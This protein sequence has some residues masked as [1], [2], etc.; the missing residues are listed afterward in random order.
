MSR[1]VQKHANFF[2]HPV[3][4]ELRKNKL[5]LLRQLAHTK[6]DRSDRKKIVVEL[7]EFNLVF[8]DK[9]KELRNEGKDEDLRQIVAEMKAN[10]RKAWAI[11]RRFLGKESDSPRQIENDVGEVVVGKDAATV[12]AEQCHKQ[13]NRP[14]NLPAPPIHEIVRDFID[15]FKD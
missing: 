12:F 11:L 1:Q 14:S 5:E 13:L 9:L 3:L 8:K 10:P 2:V 7:K 4:K 6:E 15:M